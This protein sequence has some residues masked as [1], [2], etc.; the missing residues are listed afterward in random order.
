M[1]KEFEE[2][3][4][5]MGEDISGDDGIKS[6]NL[7]EAKILFTG[8]R[9]LQLQAADTQLLETRIEFQRERANEF[10]QMVEMC[11]LPADKVMVSET[12]TVGDKSIIKTIIRDKG[13]DF[14]F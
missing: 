14:G 13:E 8:I 7:N 5:R 4:D 3:V 9:Q 10:K 1:N 6:L 11:M 2:I 12:T